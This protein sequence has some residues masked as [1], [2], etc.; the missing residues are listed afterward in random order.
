MKCLRCG[1]DT[2]DGR[3]FCDHCQESMRAYP[4][5]P[6]TAIQLPRRA[7][8][9]PAKKKSRRKRQITPEEHIAILR[10]SLRQARILLVIAV[11]ALSLAV[12]MLVY[13]TFQL[14]DTD[15][16]RNYAVDTTLQTGE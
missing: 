14:K 3:V 8:T 2:A 6:G 15:I 16:G 4:V 12:S 1:R 9:A 7:D 11:L 5:R 10:K 13:E